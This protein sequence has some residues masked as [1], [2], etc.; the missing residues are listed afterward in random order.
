MQHIPMQYNI[1][2]II[3]DIKRFDTLLKRFEYFYVHISSYTCFRNWS[4]NGCHLLDINATHTTC[5]CNH[6]TNFAVLVMYMEMKEVIHEHSKFMLNNHI[7]IYCY[8]CVSDMVKVITLFF[9]LMK[10]QLK[11]LFA[12][13]EH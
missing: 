10:Y 1:I 13:R 12:L 7:H 6:L 3:E 9:I 4:T 2:N 5:T 8:N 11:K